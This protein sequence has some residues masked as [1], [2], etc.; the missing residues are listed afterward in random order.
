M[1]DR[2]TEVANTPEAA[3][4]NTLWVNFTDTNKQGKAHL[5]RHGLSESESTAHATI[6]AGQFV[7]AHNPNQSFA[8]GSEVT[9]SEAASQAISYSS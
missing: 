1:L 9:S 7:S 3:A 8:A 5:Y 6:S 2:V 4:K